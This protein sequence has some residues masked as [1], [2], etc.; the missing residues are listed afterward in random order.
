ME[1]FLIEVESE[2]DFYLLYTT[3]KLDVTDRTEIHQ[4][5]DRMLNIINIAE[6]QCLTCKNERQF[7]RVSCQLKDSNEKLMKVSNEF[8]YDDNNY[9][10]GILINPSQFKNKCIDIESRLKNEITEIESQL[11]QNKS[12]FFVRNRKQDLIT[13][14]QI[15]GYMIS[16]DYFL[17]DNEMHVLK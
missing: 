9:K 15:F 11:F 2:Y 1:F 12:T 5:K 4:K 8:F 7:N 16:L 6:H 10:K 3:K 13:P 17:Q 14:K